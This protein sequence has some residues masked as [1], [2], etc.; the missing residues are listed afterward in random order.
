MAAVAL[1]SRLHEAYA[2]LARDLQAVFGSRLVA[3]VAFGPCLRGAPG[4]AGRRGRMPGDSLALVDKVT[5]DDLVACASHAERWHRA[6]LRM[7]LVIG[8]DE[9]LRSLDA[10]PL[11]YDDILSHHVVVA[12]ERPFEGVAVRTEDLRRACEARA[13]GHLFHLRE[14]FMEAHGRAPDVADLILASVSPFAALLGN[15][16][17]L[18]GVAEASQAAQGL[19]VATAAGASTAV[20]SRVLALEADPALSGDEAGKLYPE[21]L[22]AVERLVAYVDGWT[23]AS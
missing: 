1:P 6:D 10:F 2:T 13:K 21:Y 14:G 3:V 23:R 5:A 12:G 16:G 19:A 11:E 7:P 9:F 15:L 18:Q 17:R 20:V 22:A 8:R 4:P